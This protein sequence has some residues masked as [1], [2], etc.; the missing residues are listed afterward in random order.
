MKI[1]FAI[2]RIYPKMKG[3]AEKRAYDLSF[4]L[5]RRGNEIVF[6]TGK[7]GMN[8][9]KGISYKGI[10]NPKD[11]Y[12]DGKK[13]IWLSIKYSISLFYYL[14]KEKYDI[15]DID[16][17]PIMHIIPAKVVCLIRGKKMVATWLEPWDKKYWKEYLG[18]KGLIGYYTQKLALKMPNSI[19]AISKHTKKGII[20]LGAREDKIKVIE[21]GLN[22]EEIDK[23]EKSKIESDVIYVGRLISHKNVGLL[24]DS[25]AGMKKKK[26]II[27]GEGP[28][29]K[30]LEEKARILGLCDRVIFTGPLVEAK[31]VYRLMKSSKVL[32]LPSEREGFGLVILEAN[33]CGIPAITLNSKNNAAKELI[34]NGLNGFI[35]KKD[36][37]D[38]AKCIEKA[39]N[40]RKSMKKNCLKKA[41]KYDLKDMAD[42]V[43]KVYKDILDYN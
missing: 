40:K 32:V 8:D 3:G 9:S 42:S 10:Y 5:V 28:E 6:L 26:L 27:V 24:I 29:S 43:E 20:E 39:I 15:L 4:E 37:K 18:R 41:S 16:Q 21:P 11:F 30:E 22:L 13:S 7:F 2:D 19:I 14:L 31:Q 1:A 36:S 12:E 35:A 38:I 25:I 34:D 33:A 23:A 17:M